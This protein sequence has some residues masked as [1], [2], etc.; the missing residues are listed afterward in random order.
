MPIPTQGGGFNLARQTSPL[1][2]SADSLENMRRSRRPDLLIFGTRGT[3]NP[4]TLGP[5][6][7]RSRHSL[8]LLPACGPHAYGED[9]F[10]PALPPPTGIWT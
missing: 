2:T 1:K 10:V 8:I 9:R 7:G 4:G 6:P 3:R 5:P